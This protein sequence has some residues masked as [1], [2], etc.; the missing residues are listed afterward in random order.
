MKKYYAVKNV[1]GV[2]SMRNC[3]IGTGESEEHALQDAYGYD[4]SLKYC[5]AQMKRAGAWVE[6]ITTE[7]Y[8]SL[9]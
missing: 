5:K 6:E 9:M 4:E 8:F 1:S 3:V 7:E 2:N